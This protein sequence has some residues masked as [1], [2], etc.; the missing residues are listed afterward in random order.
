MDLTDYKLSLIFSAKFGDPTS[1]VLA[2]V[3][4]INPDESIYK[5]HKHLYV[6]KELYAPYEGNTDTDKVILYFAHAFG[7]FYKG[8][9][10]FSIEEQ[11][12]ELIRIFNYHK[13]LG[14]E[15][16][17]LLIYE[18]LLNNIIFDV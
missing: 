7:S 2:A 5:I 3:I 9:N 10:W 16:D 12:K 8:E 11:Q 18:K 4:Y 6:C 15:K 1:T 13:A 14:T 17:L